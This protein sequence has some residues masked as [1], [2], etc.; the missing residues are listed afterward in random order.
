MQAE[1]HIEILTNKAYLTRLLT[2]RKRSELSQYGNQED[3]LTNDVTVYDNKVMDLGIISQN[4]ACSSTC[5]LAI[6]Q[7]SKITQ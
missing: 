5:L 4:E 1:N 6:E 3:H 2:I 7:G